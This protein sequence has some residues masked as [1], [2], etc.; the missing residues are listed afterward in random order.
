MR[1]NSRLWRRKRG[2]ARARRGYNQPA[3]GAWRERPMLAGR[4]LT[5]TCTGAAE[6]QFVWV[7]AMPFGGPLMSSVR[8]LHKLKSERSNTMTRVKT[9][10]YISI[11]L[12]LLL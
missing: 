12:L 3:E 5:T 9:V 7:L 11:A 8:L 10:A 6:A 1:E 2:G 4:G